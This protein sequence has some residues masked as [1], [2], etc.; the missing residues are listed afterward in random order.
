M[1]GLASGINEVSRDC[2]DG[3][4]EKPVAFTR[5]ESHLK[6][7]KSVINDYPVRGRIENSTSTT[8]SAETKHLTHNCFQYH[9]DDITS[10]VLLV[11]CNFFYV[12]SY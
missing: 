9:F 12:K 11:F 1:V 6:W 7:I 10:F 5:I 2:N 3:E 8:D 4:V